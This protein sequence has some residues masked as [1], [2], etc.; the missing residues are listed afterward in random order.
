MSTIKK[1][2]LIVIL[3]IAIATLL[4]SNMSFGASSG[5]GY[6]IAVEGDL[7]KDGSIISFKG[8]NYYLSDREYDPNIYGILT[9]T[10]S[11]S[12]EDINLT[13]QKLVVSSGDADVLVSTINGPIR[14][15]DFVTSS[16][17]PGVGMRANATGQVLGVAAQDFVSDDPNEVGKILVY[18]N[19]HSQLFELEGNTN[20]LTALKAGLDSKFLGPLITLRYVIAAFVAAISFGIGFASFGKISGNSVEALGRNPLASGNIRRIVFFNFIL[21]FAIMMAGITVAYLILIL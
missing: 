16:K 5:V 1:L 11:V 10:T 19:I 4:Y 15:G 21:T 9:D 14:R 3:Q 6:S 12:I 17:T 13:P 8:G 18:L 20:I 2:S 7:G